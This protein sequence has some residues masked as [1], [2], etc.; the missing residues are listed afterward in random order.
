MKAG[1]DVINTRDPWRAR[2]AHVTAFFPQA[3]LSYTT[4]KLIN[5][6][7]QRKLF[8]LIN[9]IAMSNLTASL[10]WLGHSCCT[11]YYETTQTTKQY[12]YSYYQ[13]TLYFRNI[14]IIFWV[15]VRLVNSR[16]LTYF[17]SVFDSHLIFRSLQ[18]LIVS[19][20]F[21][22]QMVQPLHFPLPLVISET[23]KNISWGTNIIKH[24]LFN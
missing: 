13:Q 3:S 21:W 4:S 10:L 6:P 17:K 11:V 14:F 18:S 23:R 2:M 20:L 24:F 9:G 7:E 8:W 12:V 22:Q 1:I 16:T 19:F 5:T 15:S